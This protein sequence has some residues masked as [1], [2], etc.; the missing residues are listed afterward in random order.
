[1]RHPRQ[2][3]VSSPVGPLRL[4]VDDAG[5]LTHLLFA[6]REEA[7][8]APGEPSGR[9]CLDEVERQ[10]RAY[11]A[12]EREDFD[13]PLRPGGTPFQLAVWEALR[14]IPYAETRSYAQQAAAIGRPRAVRAVG[15]ANGRNPISIIVPCHRVVGADGGLTGYGGGIAQKRWL[16]DHERRTRTVSLSSHRR[17]RPPRTGRGCP[18]SSVHTWASVRLRLSSPT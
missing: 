9:S 17:D 2:T 10:L 16:L 18:Q 1:M 4:V 11:F 14:A 7:A 3:I 8:R 6:S 13:V 15:A 12:G 5:A